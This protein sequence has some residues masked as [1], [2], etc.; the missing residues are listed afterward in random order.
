MN[1]DQEIQRSGEYTQKL[2][3]LSGHAMSQLADIKRRTN[4]LESYMTTLRNR[5]VALTNLQ[6]KK[7]EQIAIYSDKI[8]SLVARKA[9]AARQREERR[10]ESLQRETA[11]RRDP[12]LEREGVP[13][14]VLRVRHK[15]QLE[16]ITASVLSEKRRRA[17]ST[18]REAAWLRESRVA[19]E[20]ES[21]EEKRV[22][23]L[24]VQFQEK[25]AVLG[26]RTQ[27]QKR[28]RETLQ[29]VAQE[30]QEKQLKSIFLSEQIE[31]LT[32]VNEEEESKLKEKGDVQ[33]A[34][35]LQF[36]QL[37]LGAPQAD[38]RSTSQCKSN[39]NSSQKESN[40]LL[41][42]SADSKPTELVY[43]NSGQETDFIDIL[44]T[45]IDVESN[46]K[47]ATPIPIA[48]L[49]IEV[50]VFSVS[51]ANTNTDQ[52]LSIDFLKEIRSKPATLRYT[53]GISDDEWRS[54]GNLNDS[55][56]HQPEH[57]IKAPGGSRRDTPAVNDND[58]LGKVSGSLREAFFMDDEF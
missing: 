29:R 49:V 5:S 58:F 54:R 42:S 38:L 36:Q 31:T 56:P 35:T 25:V 57:H 45:A 23:L 19:R 50:S 39:K 43:G 2:T 8:K 21:L 17:S 53:E 32:R 28:A 6:S 26:R 15:Y 16:L 1:M 44:M 4:T 13:S 40:R 52:N 18:R 47:V 12:V 41:S 20:Q 3:T 34:Y 51:K 48:P 24:E 27:Q 55:L 10:M 33:R 46:V 30:R 7:D 9:Q 11:G 14:S 37:L 22:R